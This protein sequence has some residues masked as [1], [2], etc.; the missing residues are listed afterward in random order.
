MGRSPASASRKRPAR[1]DLP[2]DLVPATL[3][4]RT[5]RFS[6]G[7]VL[8][9]P[10]GDKPTR[11]HLPNSGRLQEALEPGNEARLRLMPGEKRVLPYSLALAR[12]AGGTWVSVD[13][14]VPNKLFR[15]AF[16]AGLFPEFAKLTPRAEVRYGASRIDYALFRDASSAAALREPRAI[17]EIKSCT[18]VGA[19]GL[20]RFPDAPTGRGTRHLGELM[21]AVAEGLRAAVV[22]VIQ[23]SDASGF[24]PNDAIDSEFGQAL[25]QA[26]RAGVEIYAVS[27]DVDPTAV[28]VTGRVPVHLD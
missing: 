26:A 11:A 27:C 28:T 22:F 24:A 12:T 2:A 19:D 7:A 13:S 1:I 20:A 17:V 25:R 6:V 18:Y 16:D 9:T 4:G 10:A 23:R 14:G 15:V 8:H 5:G 3:V 21:K